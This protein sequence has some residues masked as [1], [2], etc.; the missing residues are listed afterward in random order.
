[1]SMRNTNLEG[2]FI[3]FLD[4]SFKPSHMCTYIPV[5]FDHFILHLLSIREV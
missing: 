4:T 3:F 5:H 2:R 1:M